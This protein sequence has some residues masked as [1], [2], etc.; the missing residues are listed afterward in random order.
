MPGYSNVGL[1]SADWNTA[2]INLSAGTAS[3]GT[4]A[5]VGAVTGSAIYVYQLWFT[6]GG[7]GQTVQL[8][9]GTA[10]FSGPVTHASGFPAFFTFTGEPWF[11][12]A[13]GAAFNLTFTGA[14]QISGVCYYIQ[15]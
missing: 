12:T 1:I 8:Q 4:G 7:S 2:G 3:G 10:A 5:I 11:T 14:G 9:S 13:K 6:C 15:G